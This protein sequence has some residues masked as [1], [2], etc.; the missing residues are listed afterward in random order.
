MSPWPC[1][2]GLTTNLTPAPRCCS[3]AGQ[4][5]PESRRTSW[6]SAEQ[7]LLLG[8]L[9]G[10]R[11]R[12]AAPGPGDPSPAGAT[13]GGC[14]LSDPGPCGLG[15]PPCEVGEGLPQ[16]L[17]ASVPGRARPRAAPRS[18]AARPGPSEAPGSGR[19]LDC[20]PS[21]RGPS[22]P[23]G[24]A[25]CWCRGPRGGGPRA[26]SAGRGPWAQLNLT[27]PSMLPAPAPPPPS[28]RRE[29]DGLWSG[30]DPAVLL[31]AAMPCAAGRHR[32]EPP[33]P[34]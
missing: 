12:Q 32:G 13:P 22:R 26:A 18:G 2:P 5:D 23:P 9:L 1:R 15:L 34:I 4:C 17:P 30:G 3:P 19:Q 29:C 27:L 31:G 28:P 25:L 14:G 11:V 24:P 8:A 16:V 21:S 10:G 33:P 20:G 6:D 7:P